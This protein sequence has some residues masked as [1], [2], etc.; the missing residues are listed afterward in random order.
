MERQRPTAVTLIAALF[1]V[2]G[3]VSILGGIIAIGIWTDVQRVLSFFLVTTGLGG[4]GVGL[5]IGLILHGVLDC[6]AA[7]GLL[8]MR[9]WGRIATIVLGILAAIGYVYLLFNALGLMTVVF[10]ALAFLILYGAIVVYLLLPDVAALFDGG[11]TYEPVAPV[12]PTVQ[13]PRIADTTRPAPARRPTRTELL[14]EE[15][16][17]MAWLAIK[18]GGRAGKQFG[19]G[20]GRNTIGRDGTLCDIVIDDSAVSAQHARISYRGGQFFITDLDSTNHT[21]VNDRKI[22]RQ[23]LMD[24]DVIKIGKTTLVFKKA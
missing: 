19:L 9:E 3:V 11:I 18:S 5:A 17:A 22:Q 12:G 1:F 24:G 23:S 16:A 20:A 7:W 2:M 21:F 15:E 6:A 10:I 8:E 4:L 14:V 13:E